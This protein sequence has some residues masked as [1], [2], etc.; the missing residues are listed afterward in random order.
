MTNDLQEIPKLSLNSIFHP[1]DF[2]LA[3]ETAFAHALKL[4]CTTKAKLTILHVGEKN[5]TA[6]WEDFPQV[7][8]TLARW[9]II[10]EGSLKKE[11][12]T[13]GLKVEKVLAFG[14]DPTSSILQHLENHP[15]DLIVLATHQLGGQP[16]FR[17][18]AEPVARRSGLMTLFIPPITRGFVSADNGAVQLKR[19]LVPIDRSPNP[20]SSIQAVA[21]LAGVL[22]FDRVSFTLLHVGQER[23]MPQVHTPR[24]PGWRW[25]ISIRSGDVVDQILHVEREEGADLISMTTQGHQGFLDALRGSITERVLRG[26]GCPL[27]AVPVDYAI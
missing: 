15:A 24:R 7:R 4:A 11:L 25:H 8:M 13:I 20:Q 9:G 5:E 14:S 23:D 26:A 16:F 21:G 2:S 1:T 27:L 17:S 6:D 12:N 3:P 22:G 19:I 10:S 18:T